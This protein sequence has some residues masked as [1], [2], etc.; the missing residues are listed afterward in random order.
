MDLL[1]A[2]VD[3]KYPNQVGPGVYDIHSPRVPKQEEMVSLLRKALDVLAPEQVWV[4]PD[5]G[6]KTRG[7]KEVE[8][9]LKSMVDAAKALRSELANATTGKVANG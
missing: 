4:N 6:L 9:A 3:F 1:G 5:C 8:P 7:W 2:F